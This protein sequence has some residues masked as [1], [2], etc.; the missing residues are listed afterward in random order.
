RVGG[1]AAVELAI[2]E[3]RSEDI[4]RVTAAAGILAS[5]TAQDASRTLG[6][7][8]A[9]ADGERLTALVRA[10]EL[11]GSRPAC[12][13]AAAVLSESGPAH[14]AALCRL[15][16]FHRSPLGDELTAA[17]TCGDPAAATA[18]LRAAAYST[19]PSSE[20]LVADAMRSHEA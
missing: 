9:G 15:K 6:A 11:M 13:T 19:S 20:A 12:R 1:A 16:A 17:A 2:R 4:D 3:L 10:L 18:A 7:A 5:S 8:L 14:L